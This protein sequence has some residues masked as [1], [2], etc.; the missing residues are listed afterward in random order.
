M[1]LQVREEAGGAGDYVGDRGGSLRAGESGDAGPD[2][3]FS[4]KGVSGDVEEKGRVRND[5]A[6]FLQP[7]I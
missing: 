6:F 7:Y 2:G 4:G 1:E 3:G 5:P